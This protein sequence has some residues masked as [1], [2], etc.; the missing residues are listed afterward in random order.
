MPITRK[1]CDPQS[2]IV[3]PVNPFLVRLPRSNPGG[4]A[5]MTPVA[6]GDK[7]VMSG[8]YCVNISSDT[9]SC[10]LIMPM[11]FLATGAA[12]A[13]TWTLFI[14]GRDQFG[15]KRAETLIKTRTNC[16][17]SPTTRWAYS[18]IDRIT[19]MAASTIAARLRIGHLMGRYAFGASEFS[20][21]IT[22]GNDS[23]ARLPLPFKPSGTGDIFVR[24]SPDYLGALLSSPPVASN[25]TFAATT[26]TTAGTWD[27]TAPL[28]Q[29]GDIAYTRDGFAGI[30]V[31]ATS[32]AGAV[33]TVS[34]WLN[35]RTGVGGNTP[36]N[37]TGSANNQV[38]L[39]VYRPPFLV[40]IVAGTAGL[41]P[42]IVV[43]AVDPASGNETAGVN[44][45][46][47]T[48]GFQGYCLQEP[49]LD[50][51]FEVTARVTTLP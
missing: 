19:I 45:V 1:E 22:S 4:I 44:L 14:E 10:D 34:A 32:G 36:A 18:R 8:P 2:S 24:F 3:L 6:V 51:V 13:D 42:G 48:W 25:V 9:F 35:V 17:Q 46:N 15:M 12:N 39:T 40:N 5:D 47:S 41:A 21:R 33:L 23:L 16:T 7:V 50:T 31:S 27:T 11:C 49:M 29:A 38:A 28:L 26:A 43:L 30:V 20:N 37:V